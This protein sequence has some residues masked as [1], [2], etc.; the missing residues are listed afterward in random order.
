ML[1]LVG[2][3]LSLLTAKAAVV[4]LGGGALVT[5]VY[6]L[7]FYSL[8][9]FG[10]DVEPASADQLR[11]IPLLR[12]DG[13]NSVERY[14]NETRSLLRLGYERYLR[15]GIPFQIR[16]PVGEL[17]SQ[18]LLPVKYLDEVKKAPTD[19][20]SFEAFSEKSFLL[21]YSRAP[22]QTEA[23]AHVVRVDLNRNLGPLVTDLWNEAGR[24]LNE[25][26]GSEYKSV[27][28]YDLV[29]G[30]VARVAS[31]ALVGAPLCRN[32]AWQRIVVETTFVAFGAAQAIKDKYTPRWRWLAPW[33]ESIQKDLRRIR[34]QS[35]DLLRP[36]YKERRDAMADRDGFRDPADTFRDVVYWLMKSGQRDRSLYGVTESQL[37]LSLTAIHTTSGTLN[38]FVYDWIAHPEYHDDILHEVTETL[39]KVRANNGEWTL[40]HVA[41]MRKLDSFIKESARLNPIGFVSTQRYSLKPYTFKDGFHLPAGTT[42]MFHSDGA[43]YDADNYP[44]P[45]KF[46][47][48]RFL[49]L[50]ETVDPNRF[51]Y[52]SVSDSSLGFGAGIHACPG[53]FLSAVVMKFFLVHF[54]TA[55]ELKYEHGGTERLPNLYNDNTSRPNPTVN[56]L[57]RKRQ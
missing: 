54:M 34:R 55:Y 18:V 49:R 53:R 16:H 4:L 17:G 3:G 56:L 33:S 8:W 42:F 23:A 44:D 12:F 20:F 47:G 36:L 35:I 5:L 41:M 2:F 6:L 25:T 24:H 45:D 10:S 31:V 52:A 37:F 14:M 26:V 40:Q 46:D 28:A 9:P 13:S 48:Y 21:N 39:A 27:P 30:F 29:C 1:Q 51:H 19:L 32:P 57:V 11:H 15:R 22:R 7:H 50:R 43:H 38:S